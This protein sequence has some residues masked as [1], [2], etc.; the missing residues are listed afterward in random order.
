VPDPSGS[1]VVAPLLLAD[2]ACRL[3]RQ[4]DAMRD[5]ATV[6]RLVTGADDQTP[7]ALTTGVR[8][9]VDALGR[10]LDAEAVALE[11]VADALVA[12]SE[13]YA[14]QDRRLIMARSHR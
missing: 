13:D 1:L 4:A 5:A 14:A 11:R 10:G 6:A 2:H 9:F 12:A 3:R 8:T 7:T